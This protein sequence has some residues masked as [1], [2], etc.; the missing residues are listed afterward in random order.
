[1]KGSEEGKGIFTGRVHP[2]L[3][4]QLTRWPGWV[5]YAAAAWSLIYGLL[6][7]YW[8]LGG[9]G[10]PFGTQ[11]DPDAALSVFG[12]ARSETGAPVIVVLGLAGAA[13]AVAM[14]RVWGRGVFRAALLGFAWT[15]ALVLALLVPDYR[16]LAR[17]A[18]APILPGGA[19][20]GWTPVGLRE[21]L[22]WPVVNQFLCIAGG[23]LWA[24][25]AVTYR[26]RTA[27]AC[28]YCG[29][30]AGFWASPRVWCW[31]FTSPPCSDRWGNINDYRAAEDSAHL[32]ATRQD[33]CAKSLPELAVEVDFHKCR[34]LPNLKRPGGRDPRRSQPA[35]S[36]A[37]SE[38]TF[39]HFSKS[40][41]SSS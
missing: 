22:P 3:R 23:I 6:G 17:V 20:F 32:H 5:G 4:R 30:V 26:R 31:A 25:A 34:R 19:L 9:A 11:N 12:G 27:G 37:N 36:E 15:I 14:A 33:G 21:A 18:Y 38:R 13:S 29:T 1:M 39:R 40:I 41:G 28:G 2:A 16:L 24:A 10:F 35:S 8:A 7:L